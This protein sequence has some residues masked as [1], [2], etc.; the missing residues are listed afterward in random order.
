MTDHLPGELNST[1]RHLEWLK[2][3]V[4]GLSYGAVTH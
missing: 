1:I 3:I 4:G 2:S